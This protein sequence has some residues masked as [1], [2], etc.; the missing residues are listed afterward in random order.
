MIDSMKRIF[1]LSSILSSLILASCTPGVQM[2]NTTIPTQP[3]FNVV[4]DQLVL[5]ST[6]DVVAQNYRDNKEELFLAML[7]SILLTASR[8]IKIRS[9]VVAEP[10]YGTTKTSADKAERDNQI[11]SIMLDNGSSDAI[12]I[13]SFD[14]FFEQTRVDVTRNE[15]GTK[16]REAYYDIVS[17]IIYLWFDNDGLFKETPIELR[18]FHSSRGVLSGLFAAGP[19]VVSKKD[20]AFGMVMDNLNT[21]LNQFFPGRMLRSRPLFVGKEFSVVKIAIDAGDF[22]RALT[23][24]HQYMDSPDKKIAARAHYNYAVLLERVNQYDE[25]KSHL[26]ASLQLYRLVEAYEMMR[27]Y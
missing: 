19:N 3:M 18:R 27:D 4:P 15:D 8:E 9:E 21:Y 23:E 16:D 5:L 11:L 6:V 25:V 14:V 2:M 1:V 20:E 22:D 10:L 24:C 26:M 12:V 7:D 17:K 13:S